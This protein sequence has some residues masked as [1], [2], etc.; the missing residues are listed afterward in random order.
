VYVSGRERVRE[1]VARWLL[2]RRTTVA[3]KTFRADQD[4]QRLTPTSVLALQLASVS[5][6]EVARAFEAFWR[7][8]SRRRPSCATRPA[9]LFFSAG[10]SESNSS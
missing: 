10:A 2:F 5:G 1:A 3:V 9:S 6:R 4:V 7:Q 8:G